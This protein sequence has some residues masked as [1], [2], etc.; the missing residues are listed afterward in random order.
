MWLYNHIKDWKKD[1]NNFSSLEKD[2]N[3]KAIRKKIAN[4]CMQVKNFLKSWNIYIN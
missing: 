4:K 1:T 2:E 3:Q